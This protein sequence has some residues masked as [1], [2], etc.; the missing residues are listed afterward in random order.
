MLLRLPSSAILFCFVTT[1]ISSVSAQTV[2]P[3]WNNFFQSN[4]NGTEPQLPDFSYA[5]YHF[6]ESELPDVSL[7]KV[8]NV[9]DYGAKPDDKI[10]DDGGIQ[11]AINAAQSSAGPAVVFFPKGKFVVSPDNDINKKIRISRSNIVLKGSGRGTGGTEIF[12]DKMRPNVNYFLFEFKPSS[13]SSSVI[14]TISKAVKR[15][16]FWVDVADASKLSAGQ[17]VYIN[18]SSKEFRDNH[19]GSLQLSPDWQQTMAIYEI[20]RIEEIQGNRVR[21]KNPVHANIPMVST[22]FE[23]RTINLI[24]EVGVEDILF[25]SNWVNY[26]E[27]FSHHKDSIHDYGWNALLLN[28]VR[29]AWVRNCTFSSWSQAFFVWHSIA[30]TADNITMSGK[31]GHFSFSTKRSYGFLVKDCEDESGQA[32]GLGT[33]YSAENTVY[34]RCKMKAGQSIDCHGGLP[35]ATLID[36]VDGGMFHGNGGALNAYPQHARYMVF[37]NFRYNAS[38]HNYDFWVVD[39]GTNPT[40]AQPYLAGF[41]SGVNVTFKNHGL[42][43]LQGQMVCPRSLFEAQ[44]NLRLAGSQNIPPAINISSPLNN[45]VFKDP[46]SVSINATASDADCGGSVVKVDFFQGTQKLGTDASAPYSFS[47]NNVAAGTYSL[48]AVATDNQGA[49]KTS[50]M[51]K[52]KVEPVMTPV[53]NPENNSGAVKIY[54]NPFGSVTY[55]SFDADP[56]TLHE[57]I[58][59]DVFGREVKRIRGVRDRVEVSGEDLTDGLYFYKII[60]D[61]NKVTSGKLIVSH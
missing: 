37:W 39:K 8:F 25:T 17:Y 4:Q 61:D 38:A 46:A 15:E 54:P 31:Q 34:L 40:Y 9:T 33:S 30:V 44:L 26:P 52:I 42:N 35:F 16:T 19:F 14:T 6:S 36:D 2:A 50:Y 22:P 24:S 60:L 47:W 7:W 18:H 10:Y 57:I 21:F 45:A 41:Q 23:I 59:S 12:M 1:M 51:V 13:V 43:E 48:T 28:N 29:D 11:A 20:H 56:N 3:L 58:L 32:H 5:G 49:L 53:Y 55:F 27:T